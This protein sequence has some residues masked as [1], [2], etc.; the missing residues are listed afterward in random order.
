[1]KKLL[2]KIW[3]CLLRIYDSLTAKEVEVSIGDIILSHPNPDWTLFLVASRYLD[4]KHYCSGEDTS[5]KYMNAISF[6]GHGATHSPERGNKQFRDLIESF[7]QKGYDPSSLLVMDRDLNLDNGTHRLAICLLNGIYTVRAKVVRRRALVQKTIDWYYNVGLESCF[8]EEI[9]DEYK[10]IYNG[11]ITSG[12]AFLCRIEGDVK[13]VADDIRKDLSVL[14]RSPQVNLIH[15][16][17]NKI[18]YGF[19]IANP[20]YSICYMNLNLQS[21]R[22]V[23]IEKL[24]CKRYKDKNVTISLSKNCVRE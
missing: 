18:E 7:Q 2:R 17:E 5:F 15:E 8:L 20:L 14:S 23:E 11:L 21:D 4:A 3:G 9:S 22:A 12:H 6:K 24:L 13:A 19:A 1:M 10:R 16:S